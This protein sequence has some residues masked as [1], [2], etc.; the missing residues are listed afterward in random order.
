MAEQQTEDQA[1]E[2]PPPAS[3]RID[4]DEAAAMARALSSEQEKILQLC[5][6]GGVAG[7]SD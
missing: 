6:Q 7:P 2:G 4:I 5:Q 1:G 3:Y